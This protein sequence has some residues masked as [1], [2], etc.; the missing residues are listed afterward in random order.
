[1]YINTDGTTKHQRKLN[2]TAFNGVVLS[3]NEV[4]DG[5]AHAIINDIE[6]HLDKLRTAAHQ[7][8]LPN[9]DMINWTLFCA[10][11]SDQHQHRSVSILCCSYVKMRIRSDLTQQTVKI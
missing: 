3:V 2:A 11:T 6:S 9:A 4:P 5:T 1:M 8:D 7:L 10:S